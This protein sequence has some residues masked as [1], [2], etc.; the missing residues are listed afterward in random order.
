MVLHLG[1]DARP[2]AVVE[3]AASAR[4]LHFAVHGQVDEERPEASA[5]LL[6]RWDAAGRARDGELT[7]AEVLALDLAADLVVLSACRT[8]LG[9]QVRGEGMLG[10]GR[11]FLA[12]GAGSVLVSLWD[13]GDAATADLMGRFYHHLLSGGADPAAALAAAQR[14]LAEA[15]R[16]PAHWAGF[17]IQG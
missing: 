6:S 5:L 8:A 1:F 13:V 16:P 4:I 10:L 17:V 7:A 2:D 14:E 12:A 3:A 9:R 11:A 15:G